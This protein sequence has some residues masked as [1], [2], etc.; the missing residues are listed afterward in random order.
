MNIF[1]IGSPQ[2]FGE[3]ASSIHVARMCEAFAELGHDVELVLP[4]EIEEVDYF[5][6]YYNV[7][8]K[9]KINRTFGLKRGPLRHMLHG[10][11]SFFKMFSVDN[12]DLIVTRNITFA[13]FASFFKPNIIVDI[14][15]PAVNYLS[16]IAIKR[17]IKAT[18][19][20]KISCNSEGTKRNLEENF[21]FTKKL[22]VLHNGVNLKTFKPNRDISEFKKD[23]HIPKDS[24]V[25]SYVG[26]TYKGR[27]IEKI[28][29]LS[30]INKDIF[31]LVVGGEDSDNNTYA[32][33]VEPNQENVLL[34]G[35]VKNVDIP[36]YLA[37]SDVLLI[38]YSSDFTIKGGSMAFD[39]SSPIKLF[40]YLASG[41][42]I[43]ASD[44]PSISRI[45]SHNINS[46]LVDP[47]STEALNNALNLVI[48]NEKLSKD[49]SQ[50]CLD[51]SKEFTWL[52]RAIMMIKRIQ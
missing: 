11:L 48:N 20:V 30:R 35:H 7:S 32:D 38:P 44:L 4:I 24:I 46:I 13:Y 25:A 26:N 45:L 19:I 2:L 51:L 22:Q 10:L 8:N 39:Y 15:H 36:N 5:F 17:F 34:T 49:L 52:N 12:Y 43:I 27:G 29:E 28:I 23:L 6:S 37:V 50:N 14:H 9:F 47:S 21:G 1:Y 40:E 16:K 3:G 42:P 33:L 31:F 41:K 18:N